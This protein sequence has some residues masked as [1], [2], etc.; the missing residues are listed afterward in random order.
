[1]PSNLK[2][3]RGNKMTTPAQ[4]PWY[5]QPSDR[6]KVAKTFKIYKEHLPILQNEYGEKSSALIR[7]LMD[8][9]FKGKLPQVEQEWKA[10]EQ[11][12]SQEQLQFEQLAPREY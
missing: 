1:L 9:Y 10:Y 2:P 7:L 8:L 11:T 5:R 3:Q 6:P 12:K 4:T